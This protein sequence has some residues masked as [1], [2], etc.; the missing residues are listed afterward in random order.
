MQSHHMYTLNKS[1]VDILADSLSRL[2]TSDL[3]AANDPEEPGSE[4]GK[5]I[6][7]TESEIVCNVNINQH[8]NRVIKYLICENDQDDLPSQSK[9]EN[10]RNPILIALKC[11]LDMTKVK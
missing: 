7:E 9:D 11:H 8:S 2:K 10:S 5:S 4:Y 1:R 3:N 6:F